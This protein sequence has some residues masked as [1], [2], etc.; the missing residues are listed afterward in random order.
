MAGKPSLQSP[1]ISNLISPHNMLQ[2]VA[3]DYAAQNSYHIPDVETRL[4]E[5]C[6][7]YVGPNANGEIEALIGVTVSCMLGEI[8]N[9]SRKQTPKGEAMRQLLAAHSGVDCDAN[10]KMVEWREP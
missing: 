7:Y 3:G 1:S 10:C 5:M 8:I 6:S 4:R 2:L 9:M